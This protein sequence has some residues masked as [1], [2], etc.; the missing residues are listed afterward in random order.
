MAHCISLVVYIFYPTQGHQFDSRVKI[1]LVSC[2]TNHPL[3]FDMPHEDVG[4][5]QIFDLS[6]MDR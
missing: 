2:S 4:K 3:Q 1:L 5:N 6:I